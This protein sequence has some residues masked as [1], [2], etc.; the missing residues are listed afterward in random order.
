MNRVIMHYANYKGIVQSQNRENSPRLIGLAVV[1]NNQI[2]HFINDLLGWLLIQVFP[3]SGADLPSDGEGLEG[4]KARKNLPFPVH[5]HCPIIVYAKMA[6]TNAVR[7]LQN[8]PEI[9]ICVHW[10]GSPL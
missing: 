1:Q 5:I 3:M 9:N 7:Q 10:P 8:I 6:Q 4:W 2:L